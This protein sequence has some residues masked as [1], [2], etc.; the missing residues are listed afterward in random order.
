MN[1]SHEADINAVLALEQQRCT[2]LVAGDVAL[3]DALT[4]ADYTHVESSGGVRDKA[5]FLA[6]MSR[7]DQRFVAWVIVENSVRVYGDVAVA[8]GRYHNTL[9]T[10]AGVQPTKHARHQRVWVRCDGQ[11]RNVAH[12]AT[13]VSVPP[14][15]I[16][17]PR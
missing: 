10:A 15:A 13:A 6:A 9:Q 8:T 17:Q 5:G 7:T 12:Q 2:A 1:T 16:D 4:A 3:L 11:W 14:P